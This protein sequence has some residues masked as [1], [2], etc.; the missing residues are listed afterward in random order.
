MSSD[1]GI[2]GGYG[3]EEVDIG[4]KMAPFGRITACC[5]VCQQPAKYKLVA[6]SK[7]V[8]TEQLRKDGTVCEHCL[9]YFDPR[10]YGIRE[11]R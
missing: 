3:R 11:L 10:T 8:D 6:K 9:T 7:E 1:L 4:Y 5:A 2:G